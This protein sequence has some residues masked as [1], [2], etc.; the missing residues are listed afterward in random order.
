VRTGNVT[1]PEV[2]GAFRVLPSAPTDEKGEAFANKAKPRELRARFTDQNGG[3]LASPSGFPDGKAEAPAKRAPF[4]VQQGRLPTQ[5]ARFHEHSAGN[6][7][8][9]SGPSTT[10][11]KSS[12][13]PGA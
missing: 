12:S 10:T 5:P 7:S 9:S 3:P 8:C 2:G 6:Q 1:P 4:T 13:G 11:A